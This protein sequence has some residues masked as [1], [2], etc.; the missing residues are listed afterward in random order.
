MTS[1]HVPTP[2]EGVKDHSADNAEEFLD[3]LSPRHH[4]WSCDPPSWVYRGQA[5]AEWELRSRAERDPRGFAEYVVRVTSARRD[6]VDPKKLNW[7]RLVRLQEK[8][9]KRFRNGLDQSGLPIPSRLPEVEWRVTV[10]FSDVPKMEAFPLMALAQ[11]HGLP[12]VLLDWTRRAWVAAY[13]AAADA[14]DRRGKSEERLAVW[15]LQR[16]APTERSKELRF[17]DA[18]GATN[19]NLNAQAGLFTRHVGDDN[20]SLEECVA[21]MRQKTTRVPILRRVTLPTT[22]AGTLLRLLSYE[23]ITGATMFPGVDGVVKAM[24]ETALWDS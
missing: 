21:R 8:L 3:T 19:L 16:G 4:L 11:H 18:P 7:S 22:E 5:N 20:P 14:A 17:Y 15:G 23:G 1:A 24:H 12:T 6:D 2:R 9:L 13:F 10:Q